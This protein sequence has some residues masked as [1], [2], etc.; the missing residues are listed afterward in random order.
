MKTKKF[1]T[2]AYLCLGIVLSVVL[3]VFN[4]IL[5]GRYPFYN[6]AVCFGISLVIGIV[7][8]LV[9]PFDLIFASECRRH[10]FKPDSFPTHMLLSLITDAIFTPLMTIPMVFFN[11]LMPGKDVVGQGNFVLDLVIGVFSSVGVA[12]LFILIFMPFFKKIGKKNNE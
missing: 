3:T 2:G 11:Y 6:I 8:G 12:Y 9:V 10:N 4:T 7:I 5:L 1:N